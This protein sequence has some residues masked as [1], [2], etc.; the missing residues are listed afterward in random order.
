MCSSPIVPLNCQQAAQYQ[1]L[2]HAQINLI[3]FNCWIGKSDGFDS[4][5]SLHSWNTSFF[6]FL[7]S[8]SKHKKH[9]IW[10]STFSEIMAFKTIIILH[11]LTCFTMLLERFEKRRRVLLMFVIFF[12]KFLKETKIQLDKSHTFALTMTYRPIRHNIMITDRWN[13]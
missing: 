5:S 6:S 13:E 3:C 8:L 10:F 9:Y 1:W 4:Q 12:F 7:F 2:Q 11:S